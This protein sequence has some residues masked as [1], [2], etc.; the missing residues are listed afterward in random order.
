[1]IKLFDADATVYDSMGL[2]SLNDCTSC[3]VTEEIN[4]TYELSMTYPVTGTHYND[5]ELRRIIYA[6]ASDS[7]GY[8]PF[9]IY[10]ISKP[11]SGLV[12]VS[13]QHI[14]YDMSDMAAYPLYYDEDPTTPIPYYNCANALEAIKISYQ[15]LYGSAL[16]FAISTGST[17]RDIDTW[18]ENSMFTI[19]KP[20]SIKSLLGDSDGILNYWKGEWKFDGHTA[21]L[22]QKR[23]EDRGVYIRYGKNLTDMTQDENIQSMYTQIYTYWQSDNDGYCDLTTKG[24]FNY[25]G[26][27]SS[28]TAYTTNDCVWMPSSISTYGR[29]RYFISNFEE[30]A[31][32]SEDTDTSL[33]DSSEKWVQKFK[34]KE[35]GTED[36]QN[37][38]TE[39]TGWVYDG[40]SKWSCYKDDDSNTVLGTWTNSARMIHVGADSVT[41]DW[42]KTYICAASSSGGGNSGMPTNPATMLA[43]AGEYMRE[44]DITKP[45]V[46]I[47]VSF[48]TLKDLAEN[49]PD[50]ANIR[51]LET[52]NLGDTVH[53]IF[54]K[55]KVE[56]EAECDRTEFNCITGRYE[57]IHLGDISTSLSSTIASAAASANEAVTEA[58]LRT[59]GEDIV[60]GKIMSG[61]GGY[62]VMH[63]SYAADTKT[64]LPDEILIMD[65][66]NIE[67]ASNVIRMNK[68]GIA[69][70]KNNGYPG[71]YT[72]GW[73]IDGIF[74]VPETM[75]GYLNCKYIKGGTLNLGGS[76]STYTT[77]DSSGSVRTWNV[78]NGA[79]YMYNSND[80]E[81]GHWTKDEFRLYY[82]TTS[83]SRTTLLLADSSGIKLYNSSGT[84]TITLNTSGDATFTGTITASTISGGTINGTT[85]TGTTITGTTINGGTISGTTISG[86]S[87]TIGSKFEVSSNGTLTATGA[88][89][90]FGVGEGQISIYSVNDGVGVMNLTHKNGVAQT[91]LYASGVIR[92]TDGW[93]GATISCDTTSGGI[94]I[95][96]NLRLGAAMQIASSVSVGSTL[97]VG[98]IPGASVRTTDWA[99]RVPNINVSWNTETSAYD[100]YAYGELRISG[101]SSSLRY[102]TNIE[103]LYIEDVE[104]LYDIPIHWYNYKDTYL[105]P[106]DE[107]YGKRIPG[108]IAEEL[109]EAFDIVVDHLDYNGHQIAEKWNKDFIIP[110][111]MKLIQNNHKEIQDLKEIIKKWQ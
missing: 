32:T 35:P 51:S 87:I 17:F 28:T 88:F 21:T 71:P 111:M 72:S 76:A 63:R 36:G 18:D 84:A 8:Q 55:L 34:G 66:P 12:V 77:T 80:L 31:V 43:A 65:T 3:V 16:P 10:K 7:S 108:F 92:L 24:S 67:T 56:T 105:D 59:I 73:S 26:Q 74:Y 5:L 81:F 95:D 2:G 90:P 45:S 78:G 40:N 85:I 29:K 27:Y 109:D 96:K 69:F 42:Q 94:Y 86:G 70:S 100:G 91:T 19:K 104:C 102:K 60:T 79:I 39:V 89:F 20:S 44:N 1:M 107:R 46:D 83:T 82:N 11:I 37:Y 64:G 54:P 68:A 53:V 25:K 99:L 93:N 15:K 101:V 33:Q 50:T 110:V 13:A 41:Y 48:I 9:R 14:S 62:V 30:H 4:G 6:Q 103:P 47:T 52:I 97:Y 49:D 23:G 75:T 22:Y 61:L 38:W 58:D 106:D 98:F 57:S